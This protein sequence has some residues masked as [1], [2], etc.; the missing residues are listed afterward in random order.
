MSIRQFP[1]LESGSQVPNGALR[2][3][4]QATHAARIPHTSNIARFN[5]NFSGYVRFATA[6]RSKSFITRKSFTITPRI[7]LR[8][9]PG[10]ARGSPVACRRRPRDEHEVP[11][12][13]ANDLVVQALAT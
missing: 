9:R 10:G 2:S 8:I 4:S 12:V 11:R 6:E 5:V 1:D 7:M 13:R 3:T